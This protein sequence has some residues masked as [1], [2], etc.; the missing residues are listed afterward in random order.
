MLI[1]ALGALLCLVVTHDGNGVVAGSGSTPFVN[2]KA[3]AGQGD[4]AFVSRDRLWVLDGENAVRVLPTPRRQE[5]SSPEFS[6]DHRWLAYLT[7][8]TNVNKQ[9]SYELWIARSN[10]SGAH[11]IGRVDSLVGWSPRSDVLAVT[12]G[13]QTKYA[14]FGSPTALDAVSPQ[15]NRRVLVQA[16]AKPATPGGIDSIWD[17]IWSPDGSELAVTL[18]GGLTDTVETVP[19]KRGSAPTVWFSSRGSEPVRILGARGRRLRSVITDLAGWWSGRGIGFWVIDFGGVRNLDDT[20]LAVISRPGAEPY[21]LAQTL[22]TGITDAIAVGGHGKVAVVS[23]TSAGREFAAGK[24][25]RICGSGILR[26]TQIPGATVWAGKTTPPCPG[27]RPVPRSGAPGS[28]VSEDPSWSPSGVLLAYTKAPSFNTAAWPDDAWFE[29]HAIYTWNSQTGITTR[30][31]TVDGS[32]VPTWSAN[33]RDLL[34]E[35]NDGLWLMP[36]NSGRAVRI[37]Y[38]LYSQ[39]EWN[40]RTSHLAN[41]SFYGQIPWTEQFSWNTP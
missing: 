34:F 31:G 10:G 25:I 14:M 37:E 33:G 24:A 27:C 5:A 39:R 36:L 6:H 32:A 3:F 26:C 29:D 20:P 17:A 18:I 22:S 2:L 41:I 40:T 21:L 4:L 9:S 19:L 28:G 30:V 1:A 12:V 15:G 35:R 7:E 8:S 23:S 13:D 11:V 16:P 38:P